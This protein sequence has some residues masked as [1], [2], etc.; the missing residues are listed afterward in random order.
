MTAP[1]PGLISFLDLLLDLTRLLTF[2]ALRAAAHILLVDMTAPLRLLKVV[3]I[4]KS[5][6]CSATCQWVLAALSLC[7]SSLEAA[8]VL[9]S[10]WHLGSDSMHLVSVN[11]SLKAKRAFAAAYGA[12]ILA[13]M[14]LILKSSTNCLKVIS[15]TLFLT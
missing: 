5:R 3:E 10:R 8:D 14:A 4:P 6:A 7:S 11:L 9:A 1:T 13:P 12:S 2:R 15:G